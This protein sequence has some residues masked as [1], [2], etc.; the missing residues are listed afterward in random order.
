M[1]GGQILW[2]LYQGYLRGDLQFSV[3]FMPAVDITLG[4]VHGQEKCRPEFVDQIVDILSAKVCRIPG[5]V[6]FFF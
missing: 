4:Q 3:E 1:V 6:F 2:K 5:L